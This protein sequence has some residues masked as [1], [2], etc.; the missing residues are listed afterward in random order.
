MATRPEHTLEK[1]P[2]ASIFTAWETEEETAG[3]GNYVSVGT[4][5]ATHDCSVQ[6]A[7]GALNICGP[8]R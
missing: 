1:E 2:R 4:A 5:D 8:K 3:Q 6:K 7:G